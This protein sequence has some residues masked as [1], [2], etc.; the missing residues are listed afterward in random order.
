M[1]LFLLLLRLIKE[2]EEQSLCCRITRVR[3]VTVD[4]GQ[5]VKQL[6]VFHYVFS[7][8]FVEAQPAQ[9]IYTVCNETLSVI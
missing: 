5:K 1:V 4:V 9:R 8:L 6:F 2:L 3:V 7:V